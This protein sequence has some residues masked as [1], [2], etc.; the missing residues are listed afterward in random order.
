MRLQEEGF[1]D[2]VIWDTDIMTIT[3]IHKQ[4]GNAVPVPLAVALAIG[5]AVALGTNGATAGP[6]GTTS[7]N[8]SRATSAIPKHALRL[9]VGAP[10][11]VHPIRPG[12]LG[13]SIEYPAI[14]Q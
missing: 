10:L 8:A 11:K 1:P 6:H 7:K 3:D 12:F 9:T 14:E 13:L 2:D 4:I 5:L